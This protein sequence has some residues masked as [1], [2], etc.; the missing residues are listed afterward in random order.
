MKECDNT[1][2][3]IAPAGSPSYN[4]IPG[5]SGNTPINGTYPFNGKSPKGNHHEFMCVT[6]TGGPPT[7]QSSGIGGCEATTSSI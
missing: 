4:I 1:T 3:P 7:W 2:L 5:P 6:T